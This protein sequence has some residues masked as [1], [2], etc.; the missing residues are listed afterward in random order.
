M[1]GA[2]ARALE[3][4]Q[5]RELRAARGL[6][7]GAGLEGGAG[8]RDAGEAAGSA[9]EGS[10]LGA[11]Q[12]EYVRGVLGF[13]YGGLPPGE[14]SV[15]EDEEADSAAVDGGE[16]A[17]APAAAAAAFE[18]VAGPPGAAPAPASDGERGDE[19]QGERGET[20]PE[21]PGAGPAEGGATEP[22]PGETETL[23]V[24]EHIFRVAERFEQALASLNVLA[25]GG[26]HST[27]P[28]L[29]AKE[30]RLS[31][32]TEL[33]C[34]GI[35]KFEADFDQDLVIIGEN[36][37]DESVD[38]GT[39][40]SG[41][42]TVDGLLP[43]EWRDGAGHAG[44]FFEPKPRQRTQRVE[45]PR[46]TQ[47][48]TVQTSLE[49]PSGTGDGK[50]G[51]ELPGQSA[52]GH[53]EDPAESAFLSRLL[54]DKALARDKP[55][56]EAVEVA[57]KPEDA[58]AEYLIALQ[59]ERG[60]ADVVAR[61]LQQDDER[62]SLFLKDGFDYFSAMERADDFVRDIESLRLS[63]LVRARRRDIN[64][65]DIDLASLGTSTAPR[66]P[67]ESNYVEYYTAAAMTEPAM[68][69]AM[70]AEVA[71]RAVPGTAA[72]DEASTG[73]LTARKPP[74]PEPQKPDAPRA[75]RREKGPAAPQGIGKG[76]PAT[77]QSIPGNQAL[78]GG[79]RLVKR[80][81]E[82]K[83]R[84]GQAAQLH[85]RQMA[86][87]ITRRK[88]AQVP[89]LQVTKTFSGLPQ[90]KE[91]AQRGSQRNTRNLAAARLGKSS[92]GPRPEMAVER[93]GISHKA[94]D[95]GRSQ[96][97]FRQ[98]LSQL[99]PK[100]LQVR[101]AVAAT[102]T[103]EVEVPDPVSSAEPPQE[104][105]ACQ[106]D[107]EK[108]PDA[109]ALQ[110]IA[111]ASEISLV[112]PAMGAL[113]RD[114]TGGL[115]ELINPDGT[116]CVVFAGNQ[117]SKGQERAKYSGAGQG[118]AA[119][120]TDRKIDSNPSTVH[121]F[122][123]SELIDAVVADILQTH[124]VDRP[125]EGNGFVSE[126]RGDQKPFR[127]IER[128]VIGHVDAVLSSVLKQLPPETPASY[129]LERHGGESGA[130]LEVP[131]DA[132]ATVDE[133]EDIAE[134]LPTVAGTPL[135]L[136][137]I[138]DP[139]E[140]LPA[141]VLASGETTPKGL[142]KGQTEAPVL[143]ER[144]SAPDETPDEETVLTSSPAVPRVR[145]IIVPEARSPPVQSLHFEEDD[146]P[147]HGLRDEP[148]NSSAPKPAAEDQL[149]RPP[150]RQVV[151]EDWLGPSSSS[152]SEEEGDTAVWNVRPAT[153][154][155]WGTR[156]IK[157]SDYMQPLPTESVPDAYARQFGMEFPPIPSPPSAPKPALDAP[158]S[159]APGAESSPGRAQTGALDLQQAPDNGSEIAATSMAGK[160]LSALVRPAA[161][162][163]PEIPE[164]FW[165]S[166][167]EATS[168]FCD[169]DVSSTLSY[170]APDSSLTE[171]T[172]ARP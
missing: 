127:V 18:P 172:L 133:F 27:D 12:A 3:A 19:G 128:T 156:E 73:T 32:S 66:G 113:P 62:K 93:P 54:S 149:A 61:A 79:P 169:G 5:G 17:A 101:R 109:E 151:S 137:G 77:K 28:A 36:G 105:T 40:S 38:L 74:I 150:R 2:V 158:A 146:A 104:S 85:E 80:Y 50:G 103:A 13:L 162:D 130:N 72:G 99:L 134:E 20:S 71:R 57:P 153:P 84:S 31:T 131:G 136:A 14:F 92:Q 22:T 107:P 35:P 141:G 58:A 126:A 98:P 86:A 1:E 24:S 125:V 15:A 81:R 51:A 8:A 102:Q 87:T 75:S 29:S 83:E 64:M 90:P 154:L 26:K 100:E 163:D 142:G 120:P 49:G 116:G 9:L 148:E 138:P 25:A 108:V 129:D 67:A 16:P 123:N 53:S 160:P 95:S 6:G 147:A 152:S 7:K 111:Q 132:G 21:D 41:G 170:E 122:V 43:E 117:F 164:G 69:G 42:E 106:T 115:T 10:G 68:L 112:Y 63:E 65:P 88:R 34:G 140:S 52:P 166:S 11:E 48:A 70:A 118:S 47:E 171:P 94:E 168:D 89:T 76:K 157:E 165:L 144:R 139:S 78:A 143:E 110:K 23:P 114:S 82:T 30:A 33:E 46:T 145:Q 59:L 121:N 97:P 96:G 60:K 4:A 39:E 161:V 155:K 56:L 167:D 91:V 37:A 55:T 159:A 119:A 45:A 124:P 135:D 44:P